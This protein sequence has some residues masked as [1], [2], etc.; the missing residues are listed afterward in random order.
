MEIESF[1][2]YLKGVQRTG[3]R[4]MAKC[5][6]HD[7]KNPSLSIAEGEDGRILLNCH[8]GCSTDKV[9]RAIGLAMRDL[10]P[11]NQ[12]TAPT[13]PKTQTYSKPEPSEKRKITAIYSYTDENGELLCQ[14]LRYTPKSFSWRT[15]DGKDGWKYNRPQNGMILYCLPDVE[16]AIAE[17]RPI[18][19]VEGEKDVDTLCS[20]GFTA[21][22]SPDGAGHGKWK[23]EYSEALKG[24]EVVIIPDN[25]EIG[26]DFAQETANSLRLTAG[27]VKIMDLR[28]LI[29][30]ISPHWDITDVYEAYDDSQD[31]T[32][33]LLEY[34]LNGVVYAEQYNLAAG[35]EGQAIPTA[36]SH[37]ID[38]ILTDE[39]LAELADIPDELKRERRIN[40]LREQAKNMRVA[41]DF[42]RIVAAF[43]RTLKMKCQCKRTQPE[44]KLLSLPNLLV[45]GLMCPQGWNVNE[46]G[47][48]PIGNYASPSPV[49]SQPVI[50]SGRY[51]N[52]EVGSEGVVVSFLQD[53]HWRDL[54]VKRSTICS[55]QSI[56]AMSDSGLA[57][58][59]ENARCLVQYLADF[60]AVNR[61]VLPFQF[62]VSHA[63]WIGRSCE[64]GFMPYSNH[65][66]FD[67]DQEHQTMYEAIRE[68]GDLDAWLR[69]V[70]AAKEYSMPV[71]AE[72]AASFASPLIKALKQQ[73]FL[74]DLWGESS[75]A[76]S[77]AM[78]AAMSVW[79]DPDVLTKNFNSTAVG[80][81]KSAAFCNSIPL[82]LNEREAN[83]FASPFEIEQMI[84]RLTDGQS[85]AKGTKTGGMQHIDYWSLVTLTNGEAKLLPETAKAGAGNRVLELPCEKKLFEKDAASMD[86]FFRENYGSAGRV[87]VEALQAEEKEHRFSSFQQD[88]NRFYNQFSQSPSTDKLNRIVTILAL[89]DYLSSVILFGKDKETAFQNAVEFGNQL[90]DTLPQKQEVD[91]AAK[92]WDWAQGWLAKNYNRLSPS[93][94]G[95][96]LG[97]IEKDSIYVIG[98]EFSSAMRNETGF[99]LSQVIKKFVDL[100]YIMPADSNSKRF[101]VQKRINGLQAWCYRFPKEVI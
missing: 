101:Q 6:A 91:T 59:S 1:L 75:T 84:Y 9:L 11:N 7:D 22:C 5:P 77:V 88:Y 86:R 45:E 3:K 48:Y 15:P 46:S 41:A 36:D 53:G 62:A 23:R 8:A 81:E 80:F 33:K 13:L 72:F 85:G 74:L 17:H 34:S 43:R 65:S 4:Y 51:R 20:Y 31:V 94:L 50:L 93:T 70:S 47:I 96:Q 92:A 76:K 18:W 95:E 61:V 27:S 52:A 39:V 73:N 49:C 89:S 57:V 87:W 90:L 26:V 68:R 55:R 83:R 99:E 78:H 40:E 25:D 30:Q 66:I 10:Y 14:K 56:L 79:G 100:G 21:T 19:V 44:L 38:S 29:P 32:D 2:K 12:R 16:Q 58:T 37:G 69:E 54:T 98:H 82:A 67:G 42:N 24:A 63:G 64:D 71:R 28:E 60:E 97:V 35:A